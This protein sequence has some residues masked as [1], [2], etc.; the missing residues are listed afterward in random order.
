MKKSIY[1]VILSLV[2]IFSAYAL[3]WQ[4]TNQATVAW[5]AVTTLEDGTVIPAGDVIKYN[6]YLANFKTDPNKENPSLLTTT[7]IVDLQYVITLNTEG[8]YLVG[9]SAVRFDSEGT[10][11]EESEVNWSDTNG[12]YTPNPFG[13][14]HHVPPGKPKNLR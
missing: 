8:R 6:V 4:K 12:E 10:L 2:I 13:I 5:D 7:P 14:V 3:D 1:V 11:L 9:V